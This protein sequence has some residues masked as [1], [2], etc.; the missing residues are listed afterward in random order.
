MEAG[1]EH[2]SLMN[3]L[4]RF[5]DGQKQRVDHSGQSVSDATRYH[6]QRFYELILAMI[7]QLVEQ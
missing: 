5:N 6:I 2:A 4:P 1:D 3:P 7:P